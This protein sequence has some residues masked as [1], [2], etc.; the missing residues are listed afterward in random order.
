MSDDMEVGGVGGSKG[1]SAWAGQM[2]QMR[3][4]TEQKMRE[5]L[6][7]QKRGGS[8]PREPRHAP[9][10]LQKSPPFSS[11]AGIVWTEYSFPVWVSHIL[12]R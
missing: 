3:E 11:C 5:Q 6:L 9:Q 8:R 7:Q 2:A 1:K 4:S 12:G 10:L